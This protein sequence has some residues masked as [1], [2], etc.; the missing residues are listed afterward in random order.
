MIDRKIASAQGTS[1]DLLSA[2]EEK[3]A[4]FDDVVV[5]MECRRRD[6][7]TE[8]SWKLFVMDNGFFRK[9]ASLEELLSE[10]LATPVDTTRLCRS[11]AKDTILHRTSW[12]EEGRFFRILWDPKDRA[13]VVVEDHLVD[14]AIKQG[15]E[16]ITTEYVEL[17]RAQAKALAL[18]ES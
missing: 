16:P 10:T 8:D 2:W 14:L 4:T 11:D 17:S 1:E 15:K 13:P 5:Q 7:V 3:F 9:A 12:T 6:G 18:G